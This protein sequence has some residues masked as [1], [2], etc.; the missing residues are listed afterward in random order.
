MPG[1]SLRDPSPPASSTGRKGGRKQKQRL[2]QAASD[3]GSKK[4]DKNVKDGGGVVAAVTRQATKFSNGSTPREPAS[5]P[6]SPPSPAQTPELKPAAPETIP[7]NRNSAVAVS[8]LLDAVSGTSIATSTAPSMSEWARH[9]GALAG[10]PNLISIMGES[11][12][13]Q[14]SSYEDPRG[15]PQPWMQQKAYVN[16]FTPASASPPT[17]ARRP[18]SFQLDAQFPANDLRSQTSS[19]PGGRRSSMHSPYPQARVGSHLPLPHQP[20]PHFYGVPEL[21]FDLNPNLGLKPGDRGYYFGFDTLSSPNVNYGS[22]NTNVVLAGYEGGI[23]IYAVS[24]RGIEVLTSLKG[25]RGGVYQAKILPWHGTGDQHNIFPLIAVAIHGPVLSNNASDTS[26]ESQ[27][28]SAQTAPSPRMDSASPAPSDTNQRQGNTGKTVSTIEAYQTTVEIYSLRTNARICTLLQA[29]RIPVKTSV[30][31]PIPKRPSPTGALQIHADGGN[32]IVASGTTGEC[33]IFKQ[34]K[35]PSDMGVEFRFVGKV[36]TCLQHAQKD[37]STPEEET[38]RSSSPLRSN[39]Q[40]PILAV[41]GRWLA[42][43]PPPS[44]SSIALNANIGVPIDGKAPGLSSLTSPVVPIESC[45]VDQPLSDGVMNRIMRETTQEVIQGA[46]WVG[47][48]GMQLWNN[49]WKQPSPQSQPR[50]GSVGSPPWGATY[51]SRTDTSVF[52]PTYGVSGQAVTKDPGLV[53]IVDLQMLE[54]STTVHHAATFKAPLGCSFLSLSPTGLSLFTASSKGDVQTVWDLMRIQ[55]SKSSSLQNSQPA[56]GHCTRVRQVAQFSRMTVAR[57]VDVAWCKP[58]GE[59][60]AMVTERGTVHLLDMPASAYTWPPPRRRTKEPE[61]GTG[62]PETVPSAVSMASNA[63]STAYGAARPLIAGRRQSSSNAQ[64]TSRLMDHASYG[65]KVL[66]AGIS[67][68]LGNAGTAINHLRQNGE[69]RV[70][71]PNSGQIPSLSCVTWIT[72][73]K[74][75]TLAVI[76]DGLVR[77]FA[78]KGRKATS[79]KDKTRFPRGNMYKDYRLKT[80][81]DDVIAPTI[82]Q[83]LSDAEEDLEITP[84]DFEGANTLVLKPRARPNDL[85]LSPEASIPQAEIESSAPYQPF[86]TDKRVALFEYNVADS[87]PAVSAIT[88]LMDSTSLEEPQAAARGKSSKKKQQQKLQSTKST[89]PTGKSDAWAFGQ[90]ISA[91]K[92]ETGPPVTVEDDF[93]EST[94][95]HRA[96][97]ASA[98]ERVMQVGENDEQIV[99]TTRRRRGGNR[100]SD[101]EEDGFFEDDCEVLDF[102]DQRV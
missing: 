75:P 1:S 10:S 38:G 33:W 86:H 47:K 63:L 44:S 37:D 46:K 76:G 17:A 31:N 26:S 100:M 4:K 64:N 6:E 20:Q 42:Y 65:G 15:P 77:V 83:L 67:H 60:I 28:E 80:L 21:D 11:P 36:W 69:N 91:V 73:R 39:P 89:R 24:K 8:P 95:D 96:L 62:T 87:D 74:Y 88:Q 12:P 71:L 18:L 48:Q 58:N 7:A 22:G 82:R 53:S 35:G 40:S 29:P 45:G 23:D 79:S 30:Q 81:S 51:P 54:H 25:L 72:G 55:Y 13:T 66:A 49:Y 101:A 19:P 14:P 27:H 90:S 52:P 5:L 2:T 3:A 93:S 99:V 68:S 98:M 34:A 9:H 56:G 102:A 50:V 43:C 57:I 92:I 70:S 41:R 32:V 97:P 16:N 84:G 94:A 59:R 61:Q 85:E 78:T